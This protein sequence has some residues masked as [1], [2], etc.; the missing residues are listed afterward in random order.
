ME[1]SEIKFPNNL[2]HRVNQDV[3]SYQISENYGRRGGY[4]SDSEEYGKS[5]KSI[6]IYI[7]NG[8]SNEI[9]LFKVISKAVFKIQCDNK[10]KYPLLVFGFGKTEFL[11]HEKKYFD[12]GYTNSWHNAN[13]VAETI[14]RISGTNKVEM[15]LIPELFPKTDI[16]S[17][18]SGKINIERDDLLVI[19]GYKNQFA[20]DEE[21][22]K[23]ISHK[24]NKL[25]KRTLLVEVSDQN[26]EFIYKPVDFY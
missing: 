5:Y 11:Q 20:L 14:S 26:V 15:A 13:R 7:Q 8:L 2:L 10:R 25:K 21:L 18:Y 4:Y 23:R 16:R 3:P 19:I 24:K 1:S 6:C 22:K 9:E 17:L 12:F